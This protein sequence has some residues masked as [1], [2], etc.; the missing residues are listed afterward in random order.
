MITH[1]QT[2]QRTTTHETHRHGV[3]ANGS[4]GLVNIHTSAN[5][6][7]HIKRKDT[8]DLL[9]DGL[10]FRTSGITLDSAVHL[11]P[12]LIKWIS[13]IV[14]RYHIIKFSLE[15]FPGTSPRP[16]WKGWQ[17]DLPSTSLIGGRATSRVGMLGTCAAGGRKKDDLQQSS[18]ETPAAACASKN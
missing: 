15:G 10:S 14:G 8:S 18:M 6:S 3:A 13:E 17:K 7:H 12:S 9:G 2:A 11:Q 1:E 16:V 5:P 4:T